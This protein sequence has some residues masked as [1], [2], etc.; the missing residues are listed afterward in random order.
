MFLIYAASW[1]HVNEAYTGL[2]LSLTSCSTWE[3]WPCPLL[4]QPSRADPGGVGE[5]V[6]THEQESRG[7]GPAPSQGGAGELALV[8]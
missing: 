3:S 4:G 8:S 7:A 1:G 6:S 5:G 2:V